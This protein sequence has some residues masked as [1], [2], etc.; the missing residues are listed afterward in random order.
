MADQH[1]VEY[2]R[3]NRA[4]YNREAID[5]KLKEQGHPQSAIDRAWAEL[6]A[7]SDDTV[8]PQRFWRLFWFYV[9]GLSVVALLIIIAVTGAWGTPYLLMVVIVM[10]L[11]LGLGALLAAGIVKAS[12]AAQ[13]TAQGALLIGGLVPFVIVTLIVGIC[14]GPGLVG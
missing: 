11:I 5:A 7:T 12:G 9:L 8:D 3:Q 4:T 10:G 14:L 13:R 1:I 2:I 6:E